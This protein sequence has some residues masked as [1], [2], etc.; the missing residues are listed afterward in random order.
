[1]N[2]GLQTAEKAFQNF[3]YCPLLGLD[4]AAAW[5]EGCAVGS[6]LHEAVIAAL[7]SSS[8]ASYHSSL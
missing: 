4:T 1:M 7:F 6:A 8:V 2:P 3:S 5:W